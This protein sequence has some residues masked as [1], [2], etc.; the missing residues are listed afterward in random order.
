M[1]DVVHIIYVLHIMMIISYSIVSRHLLFCDGYCGVVHS[2]I[3]YVVKCE[4]FLPTQTKFVKM[5]HP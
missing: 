1:D 4:S 2:I 5:L 3:I